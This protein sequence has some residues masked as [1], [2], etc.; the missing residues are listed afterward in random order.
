MIE[1]PW[2]PVRSTMLFIVL[3]GAGDV[4]VIGHKDTETESWHQRH[5]EVQGIYTEGVRASRW[6]Y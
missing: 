1:T 2:G 5:D 4:A 6:L 3:P